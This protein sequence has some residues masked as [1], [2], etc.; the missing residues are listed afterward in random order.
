MKK[1]SFIL[2]L[3]I[4]SYLMS[5]NKDAPANETISISSYTGTWIGTL[6]VTL[7]GFPSVP[8]T[9]D[10]VKLALLNPN[11]N[12]LTDTFK[13][14]N[15]SYVISN[16]SFTIPDSTFT[17]YEPASNINLTIKLFNFKGNFINESTLNI[18][19]QVNYSSLA[20][21][22]NVTGTYLAVYNKVK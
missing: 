13:N 19:A 9:Q 10:T 11:S 17:Y 18:S 1:Y 7:P 6:T 14:V 8:S 12:V 22:L 5:C 2:I 15:V 20:P 21:P 4:C 3:L 16:N